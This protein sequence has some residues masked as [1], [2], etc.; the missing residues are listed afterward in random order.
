M[1]NDFEMKFEDQ[2]NWNLK[3]LHVFH[4]IFIAETELDYKEGRKLEI[5][6]PKFEFKEEKINGTNYFILIINSNNLNILVRAQEK[7][8]LEYIIY[9]SEQKNEADMGRPMTFVPHLINVESV[10]EENRVSNFKF[11]GII[12]L[13]VIALIFSHIRL[14]YDSFK[15]TGLLLSS[16]GFKYIITKESVL[17]LLIGLG[18]MG[19]AIVLCYLIEKLAAAIKKPL[20]ISIL[21][22]VNLGILLLCPV[23]I[24]Y[25]GL[26]N[27]ALGSF[28]FMLI[29]I[30]FLKLISF[31]HFWDDVRKFI[32]KRNKLIGQIKKENSCIDVSKDDK[33]KSSMYEEIE[34]IIKNYPNNVSFK[35]LIEFLMM[36]IL[37]FQYKYPRTKTINKLQVL[38]YG[39]KVILCN[40]LM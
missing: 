30:V 25:V 14:I 1:F 20:V 21:H 24:N 4:G 2:G 31:L 17:Y 3:Y 19:L 18:M 23:I 15:K 8:S 13:V 36:P 37:C 35:A 34:N 7:I 32:H 28:L 29:T 9:N 16:E 40:F 22:A 39:T 26:Y 6:D 12:N 5:K 10:L 38:N 33:L 11:Q 27:P